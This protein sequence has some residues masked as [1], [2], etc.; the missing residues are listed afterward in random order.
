M[1]EAGEFSSL[2]LLRFRAMLDVV[3]TGLGNKTP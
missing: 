2:D 1:L 3:Y